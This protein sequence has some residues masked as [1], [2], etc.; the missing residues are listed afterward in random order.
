MAEKLGGR[1]KYLAEDD[2]E[3]CRGSLHWRHNI[4]RRQR[5]RDTA[6]P[7]NT[8]T[9]ESIKNGI[10]FLSVALISLVNPNADN[11]EAPA[12][13][14]RDP[15]RSV[16]R[17]LPGADL[18]GECDQ[19]RA[20]AIA[21]GACN[22]VG[23]SFRSLNSNSSFS[24]Y[25]FP[26]PP[27]EGRA[28]RTMPSTLAVDGLTKNPNRSTTDTTTVNCWIGPPILAPTALVHL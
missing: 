6:A 17:Q 22:S 9:A 4:D 8:N 14:R 24:T 20:C 19:N 21:D 5:E 28:L 11:Q 23:I 25:S 1:V 2:P 26:W 13:R 27:P 12:T 18:K 10:F 7:D 15:E 3:D 16:K